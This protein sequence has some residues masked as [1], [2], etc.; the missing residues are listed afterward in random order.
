MKK[1]FW[2]LAAILSLFALVAASCGNDDAADSSAET[3]Q[4]A[5][6]NNAAGDQESTNANGSEASPS[7][8]AST[9]AAAPRVGGTLTFGSA[10]P[11]TN[12]D[13]DLTTGAWD[14]EWLFPVYDR[15]IHLSADGDFIPG[16]AESWSLSDDILTLSLRSDV[17]FHDG[18]PFNADVVVA[19]LN[20]SLTLEGS[21]STSTLGAVQSVEAVD[22]TTVNLLL[23]EPAASLIGT[24]SDR[25]GIMISGKAL[26]D[27]VD[28]S[29]EAVGAGMYTLESFQPGDRATYKR[30]A[31]YWD[32][33]AALLD[34]LI[35][36]ELPDPTARLGALRDGQIDAAQIDPADIS[37]VESEGLIVKSKPTLE[38]LHLSFN[39]VEGTPWTNPLV[40]QAMAYAVDKKGIL[41]A[42]YGGSG[43]VVSQMFPPGYFAYNPD[44]PADSR[45]YNIVRA[46]E[47]M[48]ES[49]VEP[50]TIRVGQVANTQSTAVPL[51][52]QA[53]WAELGINLELAPQV[54]SEYLS[55]WF[56][57][58]FDV[59]YGFWSG[60]PDPNNTNDLIFS[61]DSSFINSAGYDV[62]EIN[63]L[64]TASEA[65]TGTE[66][67]A[68][69]H[70]LNEA[71]DEVQFNIPI[72]AR[73]Y[74]LAMNPR[75]QGL[76]PW[77]SVKLEFRGTSVAE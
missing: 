50:F 34:E 52:V 38:I 5:Q 47:L 75:V 56:A 41:N 6:S 10:R 68:V 42:I 71:V 63:E 72:L 58:E 76:E 73:D 65:V 33:Q 43:T 24:L 51:A 19:N 31:D 30:F 70:A 53:S 27:G 45:P 48:A 28:L 54:A 46:Q 29:A 77:L 3:K 23:T 14:N 40:R 62:P 8:N 18:S 39:L 60:R 20:R 69:L 13:P 4:T 11:S 32:P 61:A 49:G 55:N 12:L 57:R 17:V 66:R 7:N 22:E 15:L 59:I 35:I 1:Q 37:T 16:L 9:D 2:L 64:L 26:A 74:V 67:T 21:T 25:P 44:I 36:V